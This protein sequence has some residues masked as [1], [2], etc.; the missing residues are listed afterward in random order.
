MNSYKTIAKNMLRI[1]EDI[2]VFLECP[3]FFME[4]IIVM[5][6]CGVTES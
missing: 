6:G 1:M 4:I 3:K 2:T 5:S